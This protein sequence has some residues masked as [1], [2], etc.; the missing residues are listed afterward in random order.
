MY[1]KI[2]KTINLTNDEIVIIKELLL[3]CLDQCVSI[4]EEITI[5]DLLDKLE[6]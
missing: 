2:I 5:K 6:D 4:G 1:D 3:Y